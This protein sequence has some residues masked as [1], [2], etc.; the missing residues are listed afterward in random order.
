MFPVGELK[1][2]GWVVFSTAAEDA[3]VRRLTFFAALSKSASDPKS[4]EI[5]D[6]GITNKC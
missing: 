1:Q 2:E 6:L 5:M 4:M 3:L